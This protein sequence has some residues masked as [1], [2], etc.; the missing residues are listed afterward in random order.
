[1]DRDGSTHVRC[2]PPYPGRQNLLSPVGAPG[3]DL[4]ADVNGDGNPDILELGSDTLGI[5]LGLGGGAYEAPFEIGTG[6][7]PTGLLVA[8]LHG[9]TASAGLADLVAPDGTGGVMVLL[10]TTK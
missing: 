9:Q 10:N 3:V 5:F 6:P 2:A 1:M 7:S 8:N 4:V